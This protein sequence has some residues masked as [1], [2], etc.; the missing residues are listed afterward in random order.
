MMTPYDEDPPEE[1]LP[2][3]AAKE[4]K[5][6]HARAFRFGNNWVVSGFRDGLRLYEMG[7]DGRWR[8]L[9]VGREAVT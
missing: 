3:R 8:E 9:T 4:L 5:L 1:A 7:S 6:T 2:R